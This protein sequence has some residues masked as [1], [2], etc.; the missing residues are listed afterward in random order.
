MAGSIRVF[1]AF[2]REA[3]LFVTHFTTVISRGRRTVGIES[4][5]VVVYGCRRSEFRGIGALNDIEH[6]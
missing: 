6:G 1:L 3:V 5:C 2:G 4:S